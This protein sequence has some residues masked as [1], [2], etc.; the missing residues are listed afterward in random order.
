MEQLGMS[1]PLGFHFLTPV[2]GEAYTRLYVDVV[3][4]AQLA[5]GNLGA[6]RHAPN[7]RY[8][9][10]T[11]PSDAE[12]IRSSP[13]FDELN[14][15][16]PVSFE[17][18]TGD[19]N[20]VHDKMSTCYRAG[21]QAAN[22]AKAGVVFLTPDIVFANG[23]FAALKRLAS[24]GHSVIYV[25]AIRTLKED[26]K[27]TLS[28]CRTGGHAIS[29]HPRQLMRVALDNLHPLADLSWWDRG[30]TDLLP[31]NLYWPVGS[32]GIL[33]RCFH[34]H[35]IFVR[36]QRKDAIFFG[37][38]DDDFCSAACPDSS[39][40]YVVTDSDE[41]LSI[42]LSDLAHF[43]GTTF[44][45]GSIK[46]AAS[47]AEQFANSRHRML[48]DRVIR[49][50]AGIQD[51]FAWKQAETDAEK[52]A[53]A[54]KNRLF[55]PTSSL[56]WSRSSN[57]DTMVRRLIRKILDFRLDKANTPSGSSR[58][59]T[60]HIQYS[61]ASALLNSYK[62]SIQYIMLSRRWLFGTAAHP[63]LFTAASMIRECIKNDLLR[64]AGPASQ[65]VLISDDPPGSI[66]R[67]ILIGAGFKVADGDFSRWQ[68]QICQKGDGGNE[69]PVVSESCDLIVIEPRYRGNL[70]ETI[71]AAHGLLKPAGRL[72]IITGRSATG[73]YLPD[74]K[75]LERSQAQQLAEPRYVVL[76]HL[77]VG[78]PGTLGYTE[79][80][81]KLKIR[82][83]RNAMLTRIMELTFAFAWVPL[84]VL[85]NFFGTMIAY[86]VD[87][88]DRRKRCWLCSL[89]LATKVLR[90]S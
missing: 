66:V 1:E 57:I 36:P 30:D 90:E 2:W 5:E 62:L 71:D 35:P 7:S 46:D 77:Q 22:D 33:G 38:V 11:T 26:V 73:A 85:I 21:I 42:E 18:I 3:I 70:E 37:T 48:F 53:S 81:R 29:I 32:E 55:A 31:A 15:C 49:M 87:R 76:Q 20:V 39:S 78:G 74:V 9:I 61:M 47:W 25:P 28:S 14:S 82:A 72:L 41:F 75:P 19:S 13:V 12:R 83:K 10:Y 50:H 65:V 27:L 63:R 44:K 80:D 68:K 67:G 17:W 8:V 89:T 84:L 58:S 6:F 88:I 24:N 51:E 23:S 79:F 4:P 43:F 34:L 60:D 52:V 86:L 64:L 54:I 59:R 45:K 56:L 69:F 16:V 40:D